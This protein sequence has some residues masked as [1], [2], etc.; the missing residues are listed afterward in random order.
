MKI[1]FPTRQAARNFV[2]NAKNKGNKKVVDNGTGSVSR[3]SVE[4]K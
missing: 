3:W 2:S 1:N 4:I